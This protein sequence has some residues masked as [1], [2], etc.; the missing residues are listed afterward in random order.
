MACVTEKAQ[1]LRVPTGQIRE[2]GRNAQ[3]VNVV[4]P[5]AGDRVSA[6]TMLPE[7]PRTAAEKVDLNSIDNDSTEDLKSNDEE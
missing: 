4:K 7:A 5:N 3:G 6:I 2:T 1:V